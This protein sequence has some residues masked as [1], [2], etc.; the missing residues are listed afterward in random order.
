MLVALW[1]ECEL[2]SLPSSHS[3]ALNIVSFNEECVI[4]GTRLITTRP[5]VYDFNNPRVQRASTSQQEKAT[6]QQPGVP[7]PVFG[8]TDDYPYLMVSTL[9]CCHTVPM[10]RPKID[11]LYYDILADDE[12]TVGFWYKVRCPIACLIFYMSSDEIFC[13]QDRW[14]EYTDDSHEMDLLVADVWAL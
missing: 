12:F 10:N 3:G 2:A 8:S 5:E 14:A 7:Y 11:I 13:F 9:P 1:P 6:V 4:S